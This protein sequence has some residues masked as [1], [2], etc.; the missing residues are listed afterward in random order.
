[1]FGPILRF[2]TKNSPRNSWSPHFTITLWNQKSRDA[3]TSCIQLFCSLEFE[4]FRNDNAFLLKMS[5]NQ[6]DFLKSSFFDLQKCETPQKNPQKN[7]HTN[8]EVIFE[9][10]FKKNTISWHIPSTTAETALPN[11]LR[12]ISRLPQ[13][14]Y[15]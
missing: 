15:M 11:L 10:F 1:M 5:E 13:V 9:V 3:G 14:L 2:Y 4:D 6:A 7:R 12:A 8:F